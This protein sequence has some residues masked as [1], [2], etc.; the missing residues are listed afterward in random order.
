[1]NQDT[2]LQILEEH[3]PFRDQRET[4]ANVI[5]K[6]WEWAQVQK[7]P[8]YE[9]TLPA[10]SFHIKNLEEAGKIV[11]IRT[12]P[13]ISTYLELAAP[14]EKV[15][16]KKLIEEAVEAW[17]NHRDPEES[18][19]VVEVP[20]TPVPAP[21]VPTPVRAVTN[22]DPTVGISMELPAGRAAQ[23]LAELSELPPAAVL[24][25]NQVSVLI[26]GYRKMTEQLQTFWAK[27]AIL[28]QLT[29][30][31]WWRQGVAAMMPTSA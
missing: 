9:C 8:D 3:G 23:I 28:H 7:H 15:D 2:I 19:E 24:E 26:D 17:A 14:T 5:K 13:R 25:A 18:T 16:G 6:A 29:A 30:Y 20:P 21:V 31:P 27:P 1:M 10:W 22:T 4:R 12:S 11:V